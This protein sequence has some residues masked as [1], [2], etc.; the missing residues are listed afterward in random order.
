MNKK[1]GSGFRSLVI[2]DEPSIQLFLR[3]VLRSDGFEVEM[4]GTLQEAI[5]VWRSSKFD[6]VI[7]DKNLPDGTG[8][9]L[10]EMIHKETQDCATMV[11][12]AF[13]NLDSAIEAMRYR[14]SD[15]LL[16][17]FTSPQDLIERIHQ[18]MDHLVLRRNNTVLVEELQSKNDQL[19][20]LVVRDGLTG[21]YNH[22]YFQEQLT[23]EIS[24]AARYG[25][26]L[27]LIFIDLDNF[28]NIND[29]LGHQVGDS[30]LKTI[31]E[32]LRGESRANDYQF[33]LRDNDIAA[34]YGGD[35]FVI[36]L[37]ETNKIGTATTGERF[38]DCIEKHDF[39]LEM[40]SLTISVGLASFPDDGNDRDWLI[41]AAD[42]ALYA[43]KN[44]GRNQVIAYSPELKET[45]PGSSKKVKDQVARFASL[46][47]SINKQSFE[48]VYQAIVHADTS[49]IFGYEAFCRPTS[50]LFSDPTELIDTAER[51]G[52]IRDLGR[53][54][55]RLA[56]A[57]IE[58]MPKGCLLFVNIHPQELNDPLLAEF[59]TSMQPYIGQIVYEIT[60]SDQ[61]DDY[62]RI[63]KILNRLRACGIQIALDDLSSG[64][65]GLNAIAQIRPDFVKLDMA[66]LRGIQDSKVTRRLIEHF[67]QYTQDEN[68]QVI[69]HGIETDE[70]RETALSIGCSLLTQGYLFGKE[71]PSFPDANEKS[72]NSD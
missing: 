28:K 36:V 15:Y 46:K 8:L 26:Q 62:P 53:V 12:T 18:A 54:L 71:N 60:Q 33:R 32:I 1:F 38:R 56:I 30:V 2:D 17:P 3:E 34:R 47:E 61:F 13:A 10:I 69:A 57:P 11:M 50:K 19:K 43:A 25:S 59:E 7:S 16:K 39:H 67:V 14:T 41:R 72:L 37:P 22:A 63:R 35:E 29:N 23:K 24:R 21:L 5:D 6:L 68:I 58:K 42:I 4:A 52:R 55:R 70:E 31:A 27:G 48:F 65:L 40:P 9:T 44:G 49:E 66:F 45:A 51:A 20:A 64:Y